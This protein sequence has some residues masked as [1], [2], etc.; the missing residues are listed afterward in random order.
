MSVGEFL[1]EMQAERALCLIR[2]VEAAPVERVR[3]SNGDLT[4][5][6]WRERRGVKVLPARRRFAVRPVEPKPRP[7]G[8]V[9]TAGTF[10]RVRPPP[11]HARTTEPGIEVVMQVLILRGLHGMH[12]V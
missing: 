6:E 11:R 5:K 1:S 3:L 9:P 4:T 8:A 10:F 7:H 2:E 12:R